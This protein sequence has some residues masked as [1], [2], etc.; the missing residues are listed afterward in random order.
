MSM[1]DQAT[2]A[3]AHAPA[4]AG[5]AT[6]DG[7]LGKEGGS[8]ILS[9][10]GSVWAPP[11][12]PMD[13]SGTNLRLPTEYVSDEEV[14]K[15]I[16]DGSV[17]V[18]TIGSD[19]LPYAVRKKPGKDESVMTMQAS[20]AGTA[21]AGTELPP[22]SHPSQDAGTKRMTPEEAAR[23]VERLQEA[24][25]PRVIMVEDPDKEA[26]EQRHQQLKAEKEKAEKAK[27]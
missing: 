4:K 23:M 5:P 10:R 14:Q 18:V 20:Q 11:E 16:H 17:V 6:V 24:S 15:A 21:E 26:R 25:M 22:N 9:K 1:A 2:A 27:K 3:P 19:N 7:L 13:L 12:M 8:G